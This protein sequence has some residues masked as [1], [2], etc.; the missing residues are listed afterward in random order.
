MW[1]VIEQGENMEHLAVT[2]VRTGF[3]GSMS[4]ICSSNSKANW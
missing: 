1:S 3:R 4:A 2:S